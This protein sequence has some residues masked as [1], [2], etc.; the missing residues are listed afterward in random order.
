MALLLAAANFAK[1]FAATLDAFYVY[2]VHTICGN[3]A[4]SWKMS[5][6]FCKWALTTSGFTAENT[7]ITFPDPGFTSRCG[8]W[9]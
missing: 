3:N 4:L 9:W 7:G 8:S 5:Q 2:K 1:G 6:A